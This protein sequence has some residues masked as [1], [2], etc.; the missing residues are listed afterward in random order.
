MKEAKINL[1]FINSAYGESITHTNQILIFD[2]MNAEVFDY[3]PLLLSLKSYLSV[4]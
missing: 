4:P 2:L 1:Y 3:K